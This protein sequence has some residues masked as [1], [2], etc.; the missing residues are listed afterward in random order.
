MYH[1]QVSRNI[2]KTTNDCDNCIDASHFNKWRTSRNQSI[3]YLK[4]LSPKYFLT[5]NYAR[6]KHNQVGRILSTHTSSIHT[7]IHALTHARTHTRAP[8]LKNNTLKHKNAVLINQKLRKK[9]LFLIRL[10]MFPVL[11]DWR[12]KD[13]RLRIIILK[14]LLMSSFSYTFHPFSFYLY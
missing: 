10:T 3:L 2:F 7:A 12:R 14:L 9:Y 4:S 5:A 8:Y 6:T 11:Q 1:L 13:F